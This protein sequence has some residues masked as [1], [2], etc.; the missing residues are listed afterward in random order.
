MRDCCLIGTDAESQ[1]DGLQRAGPSAV[2][3]SKSQAVISSDLTGTV[4]MSTRL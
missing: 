2:N 1:W 4:M 3:T